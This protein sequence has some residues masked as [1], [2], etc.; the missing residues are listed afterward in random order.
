M[1]TGRIKA[2]VIVPIA[3]ATGVA[4]AGIAA[5]AFGADADKK[6][7]AANAAPTPCDVRPGSKDNPCPP[8]P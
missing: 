4:L 6:R 8:K 3:C 7:E 5:V 1:N 2:G